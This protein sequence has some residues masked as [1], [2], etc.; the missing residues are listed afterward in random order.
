M[1]ETIVRLESSRDDYPGTGTGGQETRGIGVA[2]GRV[3]RVSPPE[4]GVHAP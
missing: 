2:A 3:V 1:S 4:T